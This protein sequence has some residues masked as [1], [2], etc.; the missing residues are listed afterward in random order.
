MTGRKRRLIKVRTSGRNVFTRPRRWLLRSN[1]PLRNPER[2]SRRDKGGELSAAW[3]SHVFL[4]YDPEHLRATLRV[5][6]SRRNE[7]TGGRDGGRAATKLIYTGRWRERGPSAARKFDANYVWWHF[8]EVV[9]GNARCFLR[10][11]NSPVIT[12]F[13]FFSGWPGGS[14]A[15]LG[16]SGS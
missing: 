4:A 2:S 13:S 15:P 11:I 16:G 8:N 6:E 10:A 5:L 12:W 7:R 3:C 1:R 9:L 14:L